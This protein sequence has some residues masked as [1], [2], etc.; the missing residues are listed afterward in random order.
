MSDYGSYD[1]DCGWEDQ[2]DHID[3]G[4]GCY[5]EGSIGEDDLGPRR[6]QD[7]RVASGSRELPRLT[8]AQSIRRLL[9]RASVDLFVFF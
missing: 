2:D 5:D 7:P 9:T 4:D 8:P 6:I 1:E 3:Y